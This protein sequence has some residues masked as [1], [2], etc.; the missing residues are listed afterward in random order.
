M[1][2]PFTALIAEDEPLL[3]E[4]LALELRRAWPE[5]RIVGRAADGLSAVREALRLQPDVVFLDIRMP[6][7]DGLEAARAIAEDWAAD[8]APPLLVFV[9]AYDRHAVAAFEAQAVDYVLKP[10]EPARLQKTVARLRSALRSRAA[11]GD[12]DPTEAALAQLRALLLAHEPRTGFAAPDASGA[13]AGPAPLRMLAAALPG[14]GGSAVQMVAVDDVLVFE[15]ADK[16]LRV[17][18]DSAEYLIRTPL[19]ELQPRL[20]PEVFWQIHRGTLVRAAAIDTVRRDEAGR[21]HLSVRG[22]ANES[23]R[24]S[25][26]YAARFRAA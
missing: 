24:V 7:C 20:D 17:L 9:T 14:S 15:A 1:T 13:E 12:V 11:G 4:S 6:G 23:Y 16:Y 25:R 19:R 18:T 10:V 3:A 8:T 5:L 26:L 2:D 22:V 21:L